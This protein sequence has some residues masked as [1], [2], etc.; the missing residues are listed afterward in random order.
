ML[1]AGN[2]ASY[3]KRS[4][5]SIAIL[6]PHAA[7]PEWSALPWGIFLCVEC[8]GSHRF[9]GTSFSKTK[10]IHLDNWTDD[11]VQVCAHR[12]IALFQTALTLLI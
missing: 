5:R 3:V 4:A 6:R 11:E 9:I 12:L 7:G 8:C 2:Q 10:S 1:T